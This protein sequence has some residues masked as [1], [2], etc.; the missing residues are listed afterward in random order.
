M[1]LD[2]EHRP[3]VRRIR[4]QFASSFWNRARKRPT[5]SLA[6]APH[7]AERRAQPRVGRATNGGHQMGRGLLL[8]LI[9]VPI[10]IIILLWLFFG[11]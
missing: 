7:G 4:L 9:G 11:H 10:P 6:Q 3:L 2:A 8:W 5:E 1:G